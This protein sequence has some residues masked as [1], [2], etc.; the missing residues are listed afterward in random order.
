MGGSNEK[1]NN[2]IEPTHLPHTHFI[3]HMLLFY[4]YFSWYIL[5]IS[6]CHSLHLWLL[7]I[8]RFSCS[9]LNHFFFFQRTPYCVRLQLF[10][11]SILWNDCVSVCK[12]IHAIFVFIKNTHTIEINANDLCCIRCT[13]WDIAQL[14]HAMKIDKL[15]I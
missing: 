2:A 4:V 12:Q 6:I 3:L 10:Y 9:P 11:N 8:V 1:Q 7:T 5:N 14:A 13:D 15:D